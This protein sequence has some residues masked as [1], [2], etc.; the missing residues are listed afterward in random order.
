MNETLRALKDERYKEL[1]IT[2]KKRT[3][4]EKNRRFLISE[5]NENFLETFDP[6]TAHS[7]WK[8][9][10]LTAGHTLNPE[11][12]AEKHNDMVRR[13]CRNSK[14]NLR[15]F[16]YESLNRSDSAVKNPSGGR[17]TFGK[18]SADQLSFL[19]MDGYS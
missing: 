13:L 19:R 8:G 7:S 14:T 16:K 2:K 11:Q 1:T 5:T 17:N 15:S 9:R 4:C 18:F 6:V 12:E 3:Q 10:V